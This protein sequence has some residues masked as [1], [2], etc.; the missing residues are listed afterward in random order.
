[1]YLLSGIDW[2]VSKV[3]RSKRRLVKATVRSMFKTSYYDSSKIKNL[4]FHFTPL[5][6]TLERLFKEESK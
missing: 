4:G 5:D 6:E 1:M 2:V 3:F